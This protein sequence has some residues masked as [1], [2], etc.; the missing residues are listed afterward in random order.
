[1]RNRIVSIAMVIG[2]A[3]PA[4]A[5][6]DSSEPSSE[7]SA[8]AAELTVLGAASLTDV[9]P[10]I[11]EQFTKDNPDVTFAF[12][13]AGTD[14]L[15]AQIEQGAPADVFAGASTKY[16]DQLSGE[17]LIDVPKIFCTNQLVVITP[18]A[19]PGDVGRL[20]DLATKPVKLVIGAETVPVGSYSRTV[21]S[22]LDA[23]YGDG[24]SDEV[25]ANVVS[26]EDSVTSIV[27]KVQSGEADAGFVYIT[28][29]LAAGSDVNTITLPDEAQAVAQYPIAVVSASEHADQA[30]AFVDYVL[31][32][33]AQDLLQEAGF[34]PPPA[35]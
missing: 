11:G 17:D 13:F 28:D 29:A 22:N 20:E 33:P 2:L 4:A 3:L 10:E 31:S 19:N 27:T 9:F 25:L 35:T 26:N 7:P 34:G 16:G 21:L 15:T 6:G 32:A 8:K 14:Q 12:S 1:M 18:A 5:C 24:Y 23:V 30:Q